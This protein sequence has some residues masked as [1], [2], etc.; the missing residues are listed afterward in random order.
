MTFTIIY[1]ASGVGKQ[2]IAKALAKRNHWQVFPQHL[3]FDVA[4][5]VIGF[6]N[7]GFEKYQRKICLDAFA[8]MIEQQNTTG[9]V[10]TYCY[11]DPASHYFLDGLFKLLKTLDIKPNCIK[12]TCDYDEH[13]R[14]VLSDGRKNT[15]KIQSKQYLDSYLSKFNFSSQI[16][17]AETLVLETTQLAVAQSVNKIETY[18]Q[19][20]QLA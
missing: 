9:I 15:N 18:L 4:S 10:F 19:R 5:A 8:E 20:K 14:R 6:G 2:T 3:A 16:P 7:H 13:L 11:V 1:G 12:L 17:N